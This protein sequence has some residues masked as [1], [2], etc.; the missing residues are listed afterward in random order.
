MV[1]DKAEVR[2]VVEGLLN[3]LGLII[4]EANTLGGDFLPPHHM[5]WG[6]RGL[7]LMEKLDADD[8]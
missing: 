2:D 4:Q 8:E 1:L 5:K 3:S 6:V 7:A